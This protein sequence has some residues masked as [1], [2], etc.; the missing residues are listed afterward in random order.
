MTLH[1]GRR[2]SFSMLML[3]SPCNIK[4]LSQRFLPFFFVLS[5]GRFGEERG[6]VWHEDR[7]LCPAR[8]SLTQAVLPKWEEFQCT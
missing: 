1:A 5:R 8:C 7:G 4:A 2:L 6:L 3:D